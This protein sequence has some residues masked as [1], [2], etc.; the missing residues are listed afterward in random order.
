MHH[1]N[2]ALTLGLLIAGVHFRIVKAT[3]PCHLVACTSVSWYN[4]TP[5]YCMNIQATLAQH[6]LL[7]WL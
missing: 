1:M 2:I 3:D 4:S 5:L 6:S 7:G